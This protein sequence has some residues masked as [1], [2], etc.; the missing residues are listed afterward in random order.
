MEDLKVRRQT[1]MLELLR[2]RLV[3]RGVGKLE[4]KVESGNGHGMTPIYET[5][6][7][8]GRQ[9][10]KVQTSP[11]KNDVV[12]VSVEGIDR[13]Q[14][15]DWRL[16]DTVAKRMVDLHLG[17][18][19]G[20]QGEYVGEVKAF[21]YSGRLWAQEVTE[22]VEPRHFSDA[23]EAVE[24]LVEQVAPCVVEASGLR[25]SNGNNGE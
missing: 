13:H 8:M 6:T 17:L 9:G 11:R 18:D 14:P 12:A 22:S 21:H 20:R 4:P 24:W 5:L 7:E 10:V 23:E 15:L 19:E 25:L 16:W 1:P 3:E 2:K